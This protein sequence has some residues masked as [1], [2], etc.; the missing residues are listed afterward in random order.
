MRILLVSAGVPSPIG[1]IHL[2]NLLKVIGSNHDITLICF[3][4]ENSPFAAPPPEIVLTGGCTMVPFVRK[5]SLRK[6]LRA[7]TTWKPVALETYRSEDMARAITHTCSEH[8]FDVAIIEQ[9][10]LGQY[11]PLVRHLP[12]VL[13]PV[14][15]VSRL[16]A[17]RYQSTK[18]PLER[19]LR[20]LDYRATKAYERAVYRQFD[21]VM[22][23]SRDDIRYTVDAGISDTAT[24]YELPNGVDLTYFHPNAHNGQDERSIAFIGNMR[25]DINEHAVRWFYDHAWPTLHREVPDLRWYIVGNDP[26]ARL[27]RY[28][29]RDPNIILTGYLEDFRPTIWNATLV[30]SPLQ[31]GAG[32][33]N[34]V[35]QAMAMGKAIV[36]SPLSV[37]GISAEH[38]KHLLVAT[39]AG[40]FVRYTRLLIEDGRERL[41][42]SREA[43]RFVEDHHS[44][45]GAASKL[46]HIVERVRRNVST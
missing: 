31:M 21:G 30:I 38:R 18:N 12:H 19:L 2:Y 9:L 23:V 25:N 32:I 35:L 3:L 42:L 29:E 13:F 41:R 14:D 10:A 16:K 39:N 43:R 22:F 28:L 20:F 15:A 24:V 27:R 17:Q 46:L 37:D 11:A 7:I 40:E 44:L 5:N 33:K 36:A 34:R 4:D 26:S 1:Q 6:A 8:R 45:E